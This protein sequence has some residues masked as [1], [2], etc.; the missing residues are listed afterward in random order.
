VVVRVKDR[1]KHPSGGGWRDV[2]VNFYVVSDGAKH[3]CEVQLVHNSL[4]TARKGLPGHIIYGVVRNATEVLEFLGLLIEFEREAGLRALVDAGWGHEA[5]GRLGLSL[6]LKG[7]SSGV[8]SVCV[9]PDSLHV[10][11]G[12]IDSTARVWLLAD[13]SLVRTLEGHSGNVFSVCVTPDGLHVVT[14][15]RDSTARVW[16]LADGSL[17]RSLEG[18]SSGVYS[19]CVTPD[20]LHVVTGSIDKTARVWLLANGSLV[21]TLKG[22]SHVVS[23][24]CVTADGQSVVTGSM[25]KTA[26]VCLL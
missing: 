8:Y 26:R 1:F 19:V 21:R 17:V 18:H 2:M 7:H 20:G 22:H 4:L 9:T 11:T 12:S 23:S 6:A 15:S 16:L 25:D 3:V 14:G 10:V 24:V 13:G 5:I